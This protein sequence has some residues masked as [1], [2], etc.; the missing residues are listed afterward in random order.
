[1]SRYIS[2]YAKLI[3]CL[4]YISV[5]TE[6]EFQIHISKCGRVTALHVLFITAIRSY[7]MYINFVY[8]NLM[9]IEGCHSIK[10]RD[11]KLNLCVSIHRHL[12]SMSNGFLK[13]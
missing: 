4:S 8:Q 2:K 5:N 9:Y 7:C 11:M 10:W 3:G 13:F 6:I 12:W 1:M